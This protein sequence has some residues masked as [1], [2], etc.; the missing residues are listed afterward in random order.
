M[1]QDS[2]RLIGLDI[3]RSAALL[4][5]A[6]F[7]LV[8]DLQM[9]G[10]LPY[11]TTLHPVFYWHAR[12]VAGSFLF[13][14][15]ASLWLAHGAGLRWPAF[16]RRWGKLVAAA[17]LVSAG[18]YAALPEYFVYFGILHCIAVCSL[19]GL[20]VLRLPVPVIA[21]GGTAVM[22]ASYL[23]PSPAFNAPLLR[24]L[25]LATEPALTVDFEPLFPWVGPFLLGLAAA[26][27]A[28]QL[29]ALRWLARPDTAGLR[30]LAWP[31]RHSLVIYLLHQPLLIGLIYAGL[32][33]S[34][35][36]P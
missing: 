33:L 12:I 27:L 23:L 35:R 14:A 21:L 4:G 8:F 29:G 19:I 7:H 32:F 36:L 31:G 25:G 17:A 6:A 20:A 2:G 15:G 10:L 18:T 11:G 34:T 13:L 28:D 9:F 30:R 5:M 24:F 1:T 26:K 3:A 16:W 22:A